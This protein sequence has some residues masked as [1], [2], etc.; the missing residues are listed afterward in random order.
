MKSQV[1]AS[2][3]GILLGVTIS[4]GL[5]PQSAQ[6]QSLPNHHDQINQDWYNNCGSHGNGDHGN[7]PDSSKKTR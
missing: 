3:L 5:I 1:F 4:L 7:H 2:S 6:A